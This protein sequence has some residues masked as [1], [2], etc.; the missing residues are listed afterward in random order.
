MHE[1]RGHRDMYGAILVQETE[2]VQSGKADIGVIFCHNGD[3]TCE[4]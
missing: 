4:E 3:S 2:L 1:P